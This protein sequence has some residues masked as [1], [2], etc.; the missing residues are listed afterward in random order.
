MRVSRFGRSVTRSER[1]VPRLS[2]RINRVKDASRSKNR[3]QA[4]SSQNTSMFDTQPGTRTRS[5]GASPTTW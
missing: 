1:P 3:A 4:G 2:N 5:R